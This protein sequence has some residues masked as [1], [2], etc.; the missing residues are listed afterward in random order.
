MEEP[1]VRWVVCGFIFWTAAFLALRKALPAR[2]F[3][4]CNRLVSTAHACAAV[5]L[6]TLSVEDWTRPISPL[7]VP[8][9]SWQVLSLSLSLSL[10]LYIYI[11]IYIYI[12]PSLSFSVSLSV[13]NFLHFSLFVLQMMALAVTLSYLVYDSFCCLFDEKIHISNLVH[14]AV[15]VVGIAASLYYNMCGTE[16]VTAM[17]LTEFSSPFLHLRQLLKELGYKDTDLNRAADVLF[18]VSFSLARMGCGPYLTTV[19]LTANYPLVIKVT[20][21]GL[22]LVSAFW[23][24]KIV[25][26]MR[27]K[28]VKNGSTKVAVD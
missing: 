18:A 24:V 5:S 10:S 4:F 20:A 3:D 8:S 28:V 17:W 19:T 27:F 16:M 22:Q 14:H 26:M 6:A 12:Y 25:R 15:G 23:F 9:S 2:S 1:I 7:G 11:Y 21:L 13:S